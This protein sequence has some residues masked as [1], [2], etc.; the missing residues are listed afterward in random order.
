MLTKSWL[1]KFPSGNPG[2]KLSI[3]SSSSQRIFSSGIYFLRIAVKISWSI[4]AKNFLMSHFKTQ[5]VLVLFLLTL[6]PNFR[7]R[8]KALCV[9]LPIRQEYE[10]AIKVRSKKG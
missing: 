10:S 1:V 3:I 5:Q 4:F 7:K 2:E 8:F 9:P 6:R